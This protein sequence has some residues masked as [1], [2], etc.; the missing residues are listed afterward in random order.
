MQ[1]PGF[2]RANPLPLERR[3]AGRP[4]EAYFP[5]ARGWVLAIIATGTLRLVLSLQGFPDSRVKLASMTVVISMAAA[6]FAVF[7]AR[8]GWSCRDL[9]VLSYFLTLPYLVVEVAGLS[10]V[11]LNGQPNI[12]HSPEYSLGTPLWLH[13]VGHIVGGVTWEPWMIWLL[14]CGVSWVVAKVD[15]WLVRRSA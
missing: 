6:H 12:F 7:C 13:L 10:L 1:V 14:C 4:L 5:P 2:T 11:A 3:P 15:G 8:N 9:F